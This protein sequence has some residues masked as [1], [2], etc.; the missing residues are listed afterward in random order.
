MIYYYCR[1]AKD[2]ANIVIVAKTADPNPKL[3]GIII[4]I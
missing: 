1:A 3:P 2:G 4:R